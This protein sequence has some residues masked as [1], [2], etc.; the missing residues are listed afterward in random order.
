MIK[1]SLNP[2]FLLRCAARLCQTNIMFQASPYRFTDRGGL[3]DMCPL[4]YLV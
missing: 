1:K 3:S 4:F 2:L